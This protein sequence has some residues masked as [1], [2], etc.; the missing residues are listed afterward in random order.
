[1]RSMILMKITVLY[2]EG[3]GREKTRATDSINYTERKGQSWQRKTRSREERK[4]WTRHVHF[5]Q[6]CFTFDS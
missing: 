2:L 1:M 3:W 5:T 6:I 4:N